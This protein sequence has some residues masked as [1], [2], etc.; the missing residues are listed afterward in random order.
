MAGRTRRVAID[1]G[2]EFAGNDWYRGS[3][4]SVSFDT[5]DHVEF[6]L[7]FSIDVGGYGN[8]I[9]TVTLWNNGVLSLGPATQAQKD[10][11][12]SGASPIPDVGNAGFPGQFFLF[13]YQ[14]GVTHSSYSYGI[15]EADYEAP[16]EYS[17]A[18]Y[19]AF[20]SFGEGYQIILDQYGF[21][22]VEEGGSPTSIN[23]YFIGQG[24]SL[25]TGQ[26]VDVPTY[27][28]YL[29]YYGTGAA[30]TLSGTELGDFFFSGAGADALDGKDG[31]DMLSY[32]GSASGV[33]VNL[34]ART[35][36]GGDAQGDVMTHFEDLQGSNY[37]DT[38]T[39]SAIANRLYG[40]AGNDTLAGGNGNDTIEGGADADALDGGA[41]IDTLAYYNSPAAVTV[42]LEDLTASGG[43][44]Q[45]DTFVNFEAVAGSYYDDL[46]LA[47]EAGSRLYGGSGKDILLGSTGA[48]SLWGENDDDFMIG[49]AGADRLDG[50][51]GSDTVSY[52]DSTALTINLSAG[53]ASGG[54]ATGDKIFS[55]EN[56]IGS[57]FSD[58]M[59]GT[60][61]A[62]RL[63]GGG[64][65]DTLHGR[66]G[67]DTLLGGAG[68]DKL[69][70]E[71]GDD[72]LLGGN[73]D[74]V[75][76]GGNGA[77]V[78]TGGVGDDSLSSGA[79]N[80][81]LAGE[82]GNDTLNGG[83]GA[84]S[85]TGGAGDDFYYVDSPGDL[86][87]EAIDEGTNDRIV[88]TVSFTLGTRSYVERLV[89]SG[90]TTA[91]INLTGN[92]IVNTLVGNSEVNDLN[93]RGGADTM[94]GQA[95][96]DT[97]RV[98]DAGD[99]IVEKSGEGDDTVLVNTSY[100]LAG[101]VYVEHLGVSNA[102]GTAAIN[103]TGN[104]FANTIGGNAGVNVLN[105]AGGND[106]L[107]GDAGHDT[108]TGGAGSDDFYFG[109]FGAANSDTISDFSS[110]DDTIKLAASAF[111]AIAPGALAGSA[112]ALGTAAHDGD[113]RIVY[114]SASGNIFYDADGT[115]G[116]TQ[117]LIATLVPGT[118][119]AAADF[120][121]V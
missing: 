18:V 114:D 20:F 69:Y 37:G 50:G 9:N 28:Q 60:V 46:L 116:G 117:Q 110:A 78:L 89:A 77:D 85:M 90:S 54:E 107:D 3:G 58:T 2:F 53:T 30:D 5:T 49:G 40:F 17:D 75:L 83:T 41:G 111:G 99:I 56:V 19:C 59:T 45:G 74:D 62:N 95:G 36:S 66:P 104:G 71:E 91:A 120:L 68:A 63:D 109:L 108:L 38:L 106:W 64:G 94:I 57:P 119:L 1:G 113:D 102:A 96:N 43:D 92:S 79:G 121:V 97:Y 70:G 26:E 65:A 52:S 105:G 14:E 76:S 10:F 81:T 31:I 115:G 21:S 84:D 48:D 93:G 34:G 7:P 29:T 101:G 98:N 72:T 33:T 4:D 12:Q 118:S 11:M 55:V 22:I 103:L 25:D 6:T 87:I 39:G 80:D 32:L 61:D 88:T 27:G 112:F 100:T 67:N 73:G 51:F 13:D 16:F 86:V 44:A 35:G 47:S 24:Q 8:Y 23:G 15:G 82:D 42:S